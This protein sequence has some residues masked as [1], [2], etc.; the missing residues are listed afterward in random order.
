MFEDLGRKKKEFQESSNGRK[1][2][3]KWLELF[4]NSKFPLLDETVNRSQKKFFLL[5]PKLIINILVPI[6]NLGR[7]LILL[8]C[9]YKFILFSSGEI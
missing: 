9:D 2:E 6:F 8:F 4:T 7:T 1:R 3:E 5:N